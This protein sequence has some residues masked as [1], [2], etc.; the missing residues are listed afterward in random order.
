MRRR[1]RPSRSEA[2]TLVELL[3]VIGIIALLIGMLLPSLNKARQAA[4]VVDCEARLRQMGAAIQIYASN[5]KGLLPWGAIDNTVS[6]TDHT[7]PNSR[8]QEAVTWWYF[9]LSDQMV[10]NI[11][12]AD[13]FVRN[14]SPVFKDLDTIQGS[15]ARFVNHYVANPRLLYQNERD[16]APSIMI[17]WAQD[18]SIQGKDRQPRKIASIK[19]SSNVMMIWDGPQA[20]DQG[21]NTYGLASSMDAWGLYATSG[22]CYDTPSPAF[23]YDRAILPGQQG[24]GG[25]QDGKAFQKKYNIDLRTAFNAPDGWLTHLRF[26]HMNNTRLAALFADGH[27]DTRAVGEVKIKD[28]FTNFK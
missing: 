13:G 21:N 5:N 25:R 17:G 26:R 1:G 3:V 27:V 22:F 23:I 2:F 7:I 8:Y 9:T 14:L 12:A 15:D 10:K 16:D 24:V 18:V 4:N 6:W 19:N 28:I 11:V 20:A